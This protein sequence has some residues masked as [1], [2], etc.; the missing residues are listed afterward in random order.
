MANFGIIAV[1]NTEAGKVR[2]NSAKKA[3]S[4]GV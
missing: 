1:K 2:I 4:N 3:A